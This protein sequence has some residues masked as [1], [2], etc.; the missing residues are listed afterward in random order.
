MLLT[1]DGLRALHHFRISSAPQ[2]DEHWNRIE[3]NDGLRLSCEHAEEHGF[4]GCE[5]RWEKQWPGHVAA[6]TIR[7]LAMVAERHWN[8][9]HRVDEP[10]TGEADA[11]EDA[12]TQ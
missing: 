10:K 11:P 5:S 4:S 6:P 8:E 2:Y 7:E 12:V 1:Q 9:A 3:G